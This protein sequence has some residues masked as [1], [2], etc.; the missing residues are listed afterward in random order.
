M[1]LLRHY[2]VLLCCAVAILLDLYMCHYLALDEEDEDDYD[3]ENLP[4]H[5]YQPPAEPVIQPS[6]R[7]VLNYPTHE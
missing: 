2:K 4:P 6:D 1:G 3:I 5:E 7:Y